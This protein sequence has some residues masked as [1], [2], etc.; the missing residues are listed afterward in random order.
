MG[1]AKLQSLSAF[2]LIVGLLADLTGLPTADFKSETNILDLGIDSLLMSEAIV[3]TEERLDI[4]LPLESLEAL[5]TM[6]TVGDLVAF[7]EREATRA[8]VT[9]GAG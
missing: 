5:A 8:G 2:E 7:F 6:M 9:F 1:A 4:E 3:T